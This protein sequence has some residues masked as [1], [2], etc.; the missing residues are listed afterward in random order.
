MIN[1]N[2]LNLSK[3]LGIKDIT[4]SNGATIKVHSY[5]D[6]FDKDTLLRLTLQESLE[7][8]TYNPFALEVNFFVNVVAYYTDITFT[9]EEL[10]D[11]WKIFD[12][13]ATS[14][15]L[16][17]ILASI[18]K[19]E[20]DELN[21]QLEKSVEIFMTY[22]GTTLALLNNITSAIPVIAEEIQKIAD[23]FSPELIEKITALV[24]K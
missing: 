22:N 2:S 12:E 10:S 16:N 1:Y 5:L 8:N 4:L 3:D 13:L 9:A 7:N 19:K 14:G 24:S 11:K 6:S 23:S 15:V 18:P 17:E 21:E 20:L